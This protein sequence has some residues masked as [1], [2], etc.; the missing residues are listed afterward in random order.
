MFRFLIILLSILLLGNF[1]STQEK[2]KDTEQ[3]ET[4]QSEA[5]EKSS[6]RQTEE[7]NVDPREELD[8]FFEQGQE[9]ADEGASCNKTPE[10]SA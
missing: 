6:D 8:A 4:K 2:P 3:A 1:A 7:K 10:P 5:L 9:Q